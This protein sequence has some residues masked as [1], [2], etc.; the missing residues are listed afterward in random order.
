MGDPRKTR[1][2]FKRPLKI[3]DRANI[4]TEKALKQTYGLKNKREIWR[5]E[6]LLRKKRQSAR[7]L[8]ALPL[9]ERLKRQAELLQSLARLGMVDEKA[10]LDDVLTL[11]VESF[12]ER[13]LQTIA[14]RK[15][16]ANTATQARQF[17]AH[18]HIAINGKRV[19]APGY[20]V[21]AEEEK[22]VGYYGGK[23]MVL[24]P[25]EKKKEEKKG[26]KKE[27]TVREKF[28][29]VK[30]TGTPSPQEAMKAVK[31]ARE[32]AKKA[33]EEAAGKPA[34]KAG[35]EKAEKPAGEKPA[36]EKPAAGEKKEK[37]AEEKKE[38]GKKE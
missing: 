9:E 2:Q 35:E 12:L 7:S 36:E 27:K 25:P 18:G 16:L 11:S 34:E 38:K 29:E 14:W 6:A 4:E 20:I 28:E 23:K 13:R 30:P 15:G 17:I 22:H 19:T 10:A 24:S 21:T 26:E 32:A 37:P 33:A 31:E 8:L 5:T 1:K 3:W